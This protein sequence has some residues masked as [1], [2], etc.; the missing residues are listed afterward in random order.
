MNATKRQTAGNNATLKAIRAKMN[1]PIYL[2]IMEAWNLHGEDY[3]L[4]CLGQYFNAKSWPGVRAELTQS[5]CP[6]CHEIKPLVKSTG[7]C[8]RCTESSYDSYA[9]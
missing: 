4:D 9:S 5:R 6:D 1:G 3:A 8:E 2:V 7:C